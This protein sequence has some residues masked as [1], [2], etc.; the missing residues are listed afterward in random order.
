MNRPLISVLSLIEL[1]VDFTVHF[2][3]RFR[4]QQSAWMTTDWISA[5]SLSV[6][7]ALLFSAR[8]TM[9]HVVESSVICLS[10]LGSVQPSQLPPITYYRPIRRVTI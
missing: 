4:G 5:S 9:F 10:D 8:K 2:Q 6:L 3:P 7:S 1:L